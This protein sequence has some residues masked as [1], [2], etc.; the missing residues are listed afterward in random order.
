MEEATRLPNMS[1]GSVASLKLI[2]I[3]LRTCKE[4]HAQCQD[5]RNTSR[6]QMPRRVVSVEDAHGSQDPFLLET[7]S[8]TPYSEYLA[9]SHCWGAPTSQRMVTTKNSLA[10]RRRITPL[11]SMPLTFQHAVIDTR[12]LGFRYLW[13]DSLCIIQGMISLSPCPGTH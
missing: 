5:M 8:E 12:R 11:S 1:T 6:R 7:N 3:W 4:S 9:L 13:I 2:K 10:T